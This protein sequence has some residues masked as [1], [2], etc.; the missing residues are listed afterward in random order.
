MTDTVDRSD[1]QW[2]AAQVA[3]FTTRLPQYQ[4]F[5]VTLKK[6]LKAAARRYAH[7]AIIKTRPKKIAGFAEKIQRK[8]HKYDDP[9]NQITDL[10]AGR[11]IVHTP[12][13]VEAI[14]RFIEDHFIIDW[15]NTVDVSQ[16]LK[17]SEFG[18]RSVHYIISFKPGV[19][20][21]PEIDVTIPDELYGMEN[22]RAEIQVRTILEHA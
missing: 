20:P 11:V 21:T 14:S 17:A 12:A 9:V 1:Q 16:R 2:V 6:V 15:D 4:L 3:E 19:F 7:G 8:R 13:E 10:C 5:A 18:Y 22:G